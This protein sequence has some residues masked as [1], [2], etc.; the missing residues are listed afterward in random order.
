M[1]F[2]VPR[3]ALFFVTRQSVAISPAAD[4]RSVLSVGAAAGHPRAAL[5][6]A[7]TIQGLRHPPTD[8]TQEQ[9][10]PRIWR[11]AG[12]W[13]RAM[14]TIS[15]RVTP[16]HQGITGPLGYDRAWGCHPPPRPTH[17]RRHTAPA[18]LAQGAPHHRG[19]TKEPRGW[20]R[21]RTAGARGGGAGWGSGVG[22]GF[23]SPTPEE[24]GHTIRIHQRSPPRPP[25]RPPTQD[26]LHPWQAGP[27]RAP[28]LGPV[29]SQPVHRR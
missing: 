7:S 27:N 20:C 3:G 26:H 15:S 10:G 25:A 1:P 4:L 13:T 17:P 5:L 22:V 19:R 29:V 14:C 21:Q 6:P 2:E 23:L 9:L 18:G 16:G 28:R 8:V 24:R 12:G 11:K